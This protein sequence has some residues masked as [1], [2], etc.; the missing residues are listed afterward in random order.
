MIPSLL[1]NFNYTNEYITNILKHTGGTFMFK[2][3]W[4][5]N[6]DILI[7]CD[8]NN[9]RHISTTNFSNYPKGPKI[10]EI[11]DVL[12]DGIFNSDGKLWELHRKT[13]VALFERAEFLKLFEKTAWNNMEKKLIPVLDAMSKKGSNIDLQ[14]IF[15]R[16]TFDI[17]LYI[18]LGYDPQTLSID[19][20]F[21]KLEKGFTKIEEALFNRHFLPTWLWKLL[22]RHKIGNEKY[23]NVGSLWDK[24][25]YKF[26]K[27][28]RRK[29]AEVEKE[30]DED[31]SLL[32]GFMREFKDQDDKFIKDTLY[33]IMVAGRDT[34]SLA[35]TWF[36]YLLANNHVVEGKIYEEINAKLGI[37][38][39]E[40]LKRFSVKELEKLVY[41][42]GALYEALRLFPP[43]PANE[44]FAVEA[45]ILPSG[46]KVDK[47]TKIILHMYAMGRMET[48]W[49]EDCFDFKPERWFSDKGGIKLVSS[50]HFTTFHA[51]ARTCIGKKIA[52]IQMKIV[53]ATIIH[54]YKIEVAEG[55]SNALNTSVF[56]QLK[57]G[58]KIKLIRRNGVDP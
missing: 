15:Q 32:R 6:T 17:I 54:N 46:H 4:F 5:T 49:R 29:E 57:H 8:P 52:F 36:F 41:L 43:V 55:L 42:H 50:N 7:T 47:N 45:D 28:K 56:L 53:A 37:T 2:G 9:F 13:T 44:K 25:M 22:N 58:L 27:E 23:V 10:R 19:F 16:L 30:Q 26:I 20:P 11:F 35:L 39:C 18:L 24:L 34:T 48:I 31:M 40:K 12:G 38:N 1:W 33:S 51:G 3:P 14:K 21:N